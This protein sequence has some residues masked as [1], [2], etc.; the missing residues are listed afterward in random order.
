MI[1]LTLLNHHQ[2]LA[3]LIATVPT[4]HKK[5]ERKTKEAKSEEIKRESIESS[6]TKRRNITSVWREAVVAV[7]RVPVPHLLL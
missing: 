3:V 1:A 5:E 4:P 2:A 6:P 7:A